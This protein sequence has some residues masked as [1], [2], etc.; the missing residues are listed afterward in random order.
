MYVEASEA[1]Q[2]Y[3]S[4]TLTT[5]FDYDYKTVVFFFLYLDSSHDFFFL[6]IKIQQHRLIIHVIALIPQR[7]LIEMLKEMFLQYMI[8]LKISHQENAL[9]TKSISV[10]GLYCGHQYY[11]RCYKR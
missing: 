3:R 10:Y 9:G 8:A 1:L 5:V 2:C 11:H 7:E 6:S 4:Y